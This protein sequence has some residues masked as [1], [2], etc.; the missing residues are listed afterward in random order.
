VEAFNLETTPDKKDERPKPNVDGRRGSGVVFIDNLNQMSA[1]KELEIVTADSEG[2]NFN[3]PG[4][5]LTTQQITTQSKTETV[6]TEIKAISEAEAQALAKSL[7]PENQSK[8]DQ[9]TLDTDK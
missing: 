8:L 5:N 1:S 3:I 9:V 2:T 4:I 7:N 6:K